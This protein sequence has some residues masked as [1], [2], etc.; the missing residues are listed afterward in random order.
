MGV[1]TYPLPKPGI[2][3]WDY[4]TNKTPVQLLQ[5][6]LEI[7]TQSMDQLRVVIFKHVPTV[8]ISRSFAEPAIAHNPN[9]LN[10][11]TRSSAESED[12]L[13]TYLAL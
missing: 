9:K 4:W 12:V 3:S 13:K 7:N 2:F 1:G 6:T 11:L 10:L 5:M 8:R